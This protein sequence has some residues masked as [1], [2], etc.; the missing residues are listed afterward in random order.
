MRLAQQRTGVVDEVARRE[1]VGAVEDDVVAGDH[2][3][4]VRGVQAQVVAD[5]LDE[6]VDPG[7]GLGGRLRLGPA[8][9]GGAVD[10]LALQVRGVDGVVVDDAD[11]AHACGGEV[12]Q[13]GRAQ[14]ACPDDQDLGVLEPALPLDTDVGQQDVARVAGLLLGGQ[15]GP[16]FCQRRDAHVTE[17]THPYDG[18]TRT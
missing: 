1:V 11:R 3:E 12:Q 16:G 14:P 2:A 7:D 18:A 6:G 10:D 13:G 4:G 8:H 17:V 9:V 15:V 5:D